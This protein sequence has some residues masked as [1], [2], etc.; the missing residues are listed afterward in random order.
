MSTFRSV[1]SIER[2]LRD[3]QRALR[4]LNEQ[5]AQLTKEKRELQ[6]EL[7]DKQEAWKH[8]PAEFAECFRDLRDVALFGVGSE[9]VG[10][11][12]NGPSSRPPSHDPVAM[13]RFSQETSHLRNR[14]VGIATFLADRISR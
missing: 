11:D 8:L 3:K 2:E 1:S 10:V 9:T 5:N 12:P 13:K 7:N 14:A 6:R 4:K